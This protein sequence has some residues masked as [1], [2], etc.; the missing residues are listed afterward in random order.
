MSTSPP[1]A[2]VGMSS[3][4]A[5][6]HDLL[7]FWRDIVSA[8]DRLTDVPPHAW[9]IEDY[10]DPDPSAPD[11][12]YAKRGGYLEPVAFDPMEFGMPPTTIPAT[13]TAQLLALIAAKRVLQDAG[14]YSDEA[15]L[16]RT[17]VILGVA[18]A[19]E[20]VVEMGSRLHHPL[21]R[22]AL[23]KAGLP[24][25]RVQ[26]IVQLIK[27]HYQPWQ[28][29]TF[30]GLLGNVVAGRIANRLNLGGSNFVTDAACASSISALQAG[31]H[32]L[33]LGD[34]DMVIAGG[35]DALNDILMYMC[36]SKTPAFSPTGDCRPFSEDAD[37]TLIGEGVGML[38]LRRLED[39]ERDG[40]EIYAVI[41]GLGASSDGMGSSVYAP[42]PEGQANALRRAYEHADYSPATVEL[43]EAHG[44]A[45]KAGDAAEA[46]GLTSVF[47]PANEAGRAW[48]ALGSVK[49]QIGHTKAA[50]GSAGLIKVALAL[51]HRVLPPTLKVSKPNSLLGLEDGPL[52]INTDT[53]PW[54][55]GSDHPRRGSV[56][57]FGFGGSNF[58]VALE[59]YTGPGNRPKKLR[60]WSEDLLV[61]SA[62]DRDSL[63]SRIEKVRSQIEQGYSLGTLAAQA[64]EDFDANAHARVAVV[65]S[66]AHELGIKLDKAVEVIRAGSEESLPDPDVHFGFGPSKV[67]RLAFIFPGQG[68]QYV[69]MG[70]EAAMTFDCARAVWDEAV[71]IEEFAGDRLDRAVFPP[72]AFTDDERAQQFNTL[73]AMATAQPAI[74]AVS[75]GFLHLLRELGVE[76]DAMA[77]HSF[78][79]LSALA[80]SGR[81]EEKALLATARKRG[82]LMAE[83][84]AS[85]EGAMIAVPSDAETVR[86]LIDPSDDVVIA[87]DNAP[88]EVV[89]A[90]SESAITNMTTKL[91]SEGLRSIRLPVASAFHSNIVSD[92]CDPFHD[93]LAE[94]KWS[95]GG[96]EVYANKTA[97]VYPKTPKAAR[98]LLADQLASP[99]RFREMIEAMHSSGV[100]HFVEVGPG[101]ILTKLVGRC[102]EGREHVAISLD[103]KKVDGLRAFWRGIGALA[104]EGVS[105]NLLALSEGYQVPDAPVE[106]K[107]FEIMITGFNH[108]RPYP[109]Q[110]GAAGRASPNPEEVAEPTTEART[111]ESEVSTPAPL[112]SG[113]VD[114]SVAAEIH[115]ATIEAHR[116]YQELMA[117]SHRSFLDMAAVALGQA[118]SAASVEGR[119]PTGARLDRRPEEPTAPPV[120]VPNVQ[121]RQEHTLSS[122][123]AI[124]E[125]VAP[126]VVGA[127]M[128]V[129]RSEPV[130]AAVD[131]TAL[132]LEV[133]SEKTGYPVEMLD[134]DMEME[135]GLGIDSIKQVEILSELQERLPGI[136]EIAP[137]ELASLRTLRDVAEKLAVGAPGVPSSN[138]TATT[139]TPVPEVT[140]ERT[141]L[142]V[143]NMVIDPTEI[144]AFVPRLVK[145]QRPGFGLFALAGDRGVEITDENPSLAEALSAGLSARGV[146]AT[147]VERPSE[148]ACAVICLAG[149]SDMPAGPVGALHVHQSAI[150]VAKVVAQHPKAEERLFVTVQSTGGCFGLDGSPGDHAW[151]GGLA[152]VVKTA[153]REWPGAS[154]KAID[155]A[156]PE[157]SADAILDELFFGG[158]ALEVAY[159]TDGTRSVVQ[160]ETL[161]T[162]D[163][164][165]PALE[166]GSVV[167]VSGGARGVTASSVAK[168]AE[169]WKVKLALLGRSKLAEWP[170]GVPLT[171][172][173]VQITGALASSAKALGERV[174][175]SAIQKQAQSLAGS[176]E[177]RMSLA[178]LDARGIEAIY[179]TADVTSLEQVEAALD[180]VRETWGSIDGIV[181]GAGVLRDKSIADMTPDR[182][183]EVFGPKV[184]GLGVL[185]EATQDDEIQL[186]AL[187]SSI[188]ARA[189]NAGQVAYAAANEVL[190]KVAASEAARR[191][192]R[193]RVRS[194]NWGPWAGGMVDEALAAHFERQGIALLGVDAGAQFFVDE[195]G[196]T[197]VGVERVV[198]AAPSF[199][200][201]TQSFT[202]GGGEGD[203]KEIGSS[204]VAGLALRLGEALRPVGT[205]RAYLEDFVITLPGQE[206]A[207]G[208]HSV[209]VEPIVAA[210]PSYRLVFRDNDGAV[211]HETIVRYSENGAGSPPQVPSGGLEPW[212]LEVGT[213]YDTVLGTATDR[214]AILNLEGLSEEGGMAL[215][216]SAASLG[217]PMKDFV[218]GFD[219]AAFE[220]LLQLAELWTHQKA[221]AMQRLAGMGQ[222]VVHSLETIPER[223]R[224][225]FR[226]RK[227]ER[228][229]LFDFIIA[230]EEGDLVAE[231]REVQFDAPGA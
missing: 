207:A 213:A 105:M 167:V 226:A 98:R 50:A 83:A 227:T 10:Y 146:S 99:V 164:R 86:S 221:G 169:K 196:L 216:R 80:A 100:T 54:I 78:G 199:P 152:G 189:G 63:A 42:R 97:D 203:K 77:G 198:L 222:M 108:D 70:A 179:L 67:E 68:S 106:A 125:S 1:I 155:V 148:S 173:P 95:D 195:L 28:E 41:R 65:A 34:S 114:H 231:L 144:T 82:E 73:T 102:L 58:H 215:L 66:D 204:D 230:T 113:N 177:V 121:S 127:P 31:L 191:G 192:D 117:D 87:N 75:L 40:D 187:F 225:A 39:A 111:A 88:T 12:T 197:G 35:V 151:R 55:R 112:V 47:G 172:D 71:D 126:A 18:S 52:Y 93:H 149:L 214:R 163:S 84:A 122:S 92:S 13:D 188:A 29:S 32:E 180:Q 2:I 15:D 224:S 194:Y 72:P 56:S 160:V 208:A 185:L 211:H 6:S 44:T 153:A 141:A 145:D 159:A 229:T 74:A 64:A 14:K 128:P 184:G 26:E 131:V 4:F 174:D 90:G 120:P 53:R 183:A 57:S 16:S 81:M 60:A 21:W 168:L 62:T 59:E 210:I 162:D 89:L 193:C 182:V 134:L 142:V 170:E 116:R 205:M 76:A 91:K 157:R 49:S 37:G 136:P 124:Q 212:P 43:V 150:A 22:N 137:D 51:H 143:P 186:I 129:E 202:L 23:R 176:A 175:F 223:M 161:A 69:G 156:D 219:P 46:R 85:K 220:G 217:W 33:Y 130:S 61:L 5:G 17:S 36:F 201:T 9:L 115:R 101:R 228:G 110:D 25:S 132:A 38:A 7:G 154:L 133:V 147:V 178:E 11:M 123:P 94:L 107:P 24:E 19:T 158:P 139:S 109:P 165:G 135:A 206:M 166:P 181:H 104:A 103:D 140:Q 8:T 218:K 118:S 20:L 3:L 119:A 30:P 79:E 138:S 45:T 190:N 171:T 27:D 96:P 48:C 200:A 209:D